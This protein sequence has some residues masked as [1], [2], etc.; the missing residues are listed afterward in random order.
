MDT[1]HEFFESHYNKFLLYCHKD[2]AK[3]WDSFFPTYFELL[4]I[5]DFLSPPV[6]KA[7]GNPSEAD[8]AAL[9]SK[10]LKAGKQSKKRRELNEYGRMK[11]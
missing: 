11:D 4:P 8:R 6:A 9:G 5:E 1:Q 3:F 10:E 2:K 7:L